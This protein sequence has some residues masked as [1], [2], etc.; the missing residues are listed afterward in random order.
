MSEHVAGDTPQTLSLGKYYDDLVKQRVESGRY[1]T[2]GE[3]LR[4]GLRHL[5]SRERSEA[6]NLALL[7]EEIRK[8]LEDPVRIDGE[9][10]FREIDAIIDGYE[11]KQ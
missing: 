5:E 2:A 6:E 8:G 10:V 7:R 1:A 3:V 4:D 9:T 11:G